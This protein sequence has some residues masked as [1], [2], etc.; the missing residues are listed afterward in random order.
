MFG[1]KM[2]KSQN[3][4]Q[5]QSRGQYFKLKY[6]AYCRAQLPPKEAGQTV[7]DVVQFA[8]FFLCT[9]THRLMKDPVWKTYTKEEILVEY[10]SY[11][12]LDQEYKS[13]FEVDM[14][15]TEGALE[16][17]VDDFLTWTSKQDEKDKEELEK[18]PD[19]LSFSPGKE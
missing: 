12:M 13:K 18:L 14:G 5:N 16:S 4:N 3:L 1:E 9:K 15:T 17:E 7:H 11:L 10:F 6:I 19:N 2:Q 8:K